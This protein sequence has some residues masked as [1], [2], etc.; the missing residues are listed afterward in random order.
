MPRL[1]TR[2]GRTKQGER[3]HARLIGYLTATGTLVT[4]LATLIAAVTAF[5]ALFVA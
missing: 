2:H 3:Q 5:T 1:A 4:A